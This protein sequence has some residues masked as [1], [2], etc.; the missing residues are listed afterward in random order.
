MLNTVTINKVNEEHIFKDTVQEQKKM[1]SCLSRNWSN[2]KIANQT[3]RLSL[4]WAEGCCWSNAHGNNRSCNLANLFDRFMLSD[5]PS[6][7]SSGINGASTKPHAHTSVTQSAKHKHLSNFTTL[8][9]FINY[10]KWY[11]CFSTAHDYDQVRK[12]EL[13][14]DHAT[15]VTIGHI[16]LIINE[17]ALQRIGNHE[18]TA[19]FTIISCKIALLCRF[20]LYTVFTRPCVMVSVAR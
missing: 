16:I 6:F 4:L 11:S 9:S 1:L 13:H 20:L 10:L 15:S 2:N 5:K 18:K 8:N 3:L 12:T 17:G 14:T 19:R 7:R